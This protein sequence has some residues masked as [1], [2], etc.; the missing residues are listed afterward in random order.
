MVLTPREARE[1]VE[2]VT[3]IERSIRNIAT[4]V[5][6]ATRKTTSGLDEV[7]R[8][9]EKVGQTGVEAAKAI[10][11]EHANTIRLMT[12]GWSDFESEAKAAIDAVKSK[13]NEI[14]RHPGI[15]MLFGN[16]D[17]PGMISGQRG[18]MFS[19]IGS[20]AK[21]MQTEV[22]SVMPVGGLIGLLL[23]GGKLNIKDNV[24]GQQVLGTFQQSMRSSSTDIKAFGARLQDL[25]TDFGKGSNVI[26]RYTSTLQNLAAAGVTEDQALQRVG[27]ATTKLGSDIA[28]ALTALDKHFELAQGQAAQF[29]T[30][31]MRDMGISLSDATYKLQELGDAFRGNGASAATFIGTLLQGASSIRMQATEVSDLVKTYGT[32]HNAVSQLAPGMSPQAVTESSLRAFGGLTQS[33]SGFGDVQ[34]AFLGRAMGLGG[35]DPFK[36]ITQ[37]ETGASGDTPIKRTEFLTN[38]VSKMTELGKSQGGSDIGRLEHVF[39]HSRMFNL[40]SEVARALAGAAFSGPGGTTAQPGTKAFEDAM[41]S[42]TALM[43]KQQDPM[44]KLVENL[45]KVVASL[46]TLLISLL[47]GMIGVMASVG[48]GIVAAINNPLHNNGGDIINAGLA[49]ETGKIRS[50]FGRTT[51]AIKAAGDSSFMAISEAIGGLPITTEAQAADFAKK[52]PGV[53]PPHQKTASAVTNAA[54]SPLGAAAIGAANPVAG[55]FAMNAGATEWALEKLGIKFRFAPVV[56]VIVDTIGGTGEPETH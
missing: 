19:A 22:M 44:V 30:V 33:V 6:E 32:L 38:L 12:D 43:E 10:A 2:S 37:F 51:N 17:G 5:E 15:K 24:L 47:S 13:M 23:S 46:G 28:G 7:N 56:Q 27:G 41:Q 14:E 36:A 29:A 26:Q 16:P 52:N 11:K 35:G 54:T 20:L 21:D 39:K 45:Q 55:V 40:P 34:K 53:L 4:S 49:Q 18:G 50:S 3:R 48:A 1:L 25:E 31:M 9:V 42:V 8:K